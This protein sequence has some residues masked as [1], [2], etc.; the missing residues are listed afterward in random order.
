M[1]DA[2]YLWICGST[3]R[4]LASERRQWAELKNESHNASDNM[5]WPRSN[6]RLRCWPRSPAA[7]AVQTTD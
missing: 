7:E 2:L 6:V 3:E 5:M 1:F 4:R